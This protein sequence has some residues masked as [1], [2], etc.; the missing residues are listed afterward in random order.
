MT[1]LKLVKDFYRLGVRLTTE[2]RRRTI[3]R[4]SFSNN[5]RPMLPNATFA[6]NSADGIQPVA[7]IP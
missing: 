7:S 1:S 6:E 2:Y 3:T 5:F 4:P